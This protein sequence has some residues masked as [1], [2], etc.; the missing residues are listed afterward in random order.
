MHSYVLHPPLLDELGLAAA[1]ADYVEGF[2]RRSGVKVSLD[3]P[4]DLA[5]F[6]DEVEMTLFRVVQES[7]GNIH[8]HA[9]TSAARVG[10]AADAEQVVLEVSDQGRGMSADTMRAIENG[11]GSPGVGIAGMRERLRLVGGRLEVES[12]EGGTTIRAI[13]PLRREPT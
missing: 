9:G 4:P 7:L 6:P 10:L 3:A 13:V 5:R 8:R 2:S 1:I 11:R 12:G